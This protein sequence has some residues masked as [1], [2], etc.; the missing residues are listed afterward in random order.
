M[1]IYQCSR[2]GF[3]RNQKSTLVFHITRKNLCKSK[4]GDVERSIIETEDLPTNTMMYQCARCGYFIDKKHTMDRHM[5]K[6]Y[7]CNPTKADVQRSI[8]RF[9]TSPQ[10][11]TPTTIQNQPITAHNHITININNTS[12]IDN[13]VDAIQRMI[14]ISSVN[15][16]TVPTTANQNG[17]SQD[18]SVT[19]R[20]R[21][22]QP[23]SKALRTKVWKTQQRDTNSVGMDS[24]PCSCCL[25]RVSIYD[26][27]CGHLVSVA[28]GG[29]TTL[30]NLRVMCS[31]CNSSMGRTNFD[32]FHA[33]F[34]TSSSHRP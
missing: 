7:D 10:V 19:Q 6:P 21:H 25:E 32:E 17:S 23:L 18:I 8:I 28:N 26:F 1:T 34:L 24:V 31:T 11:A 16:P 14:P 20:Q 4:N 12:N 5:L 3:S 33:A 15:V 9:S 29:P 2:C 13:V 30:E 22:R 27:E